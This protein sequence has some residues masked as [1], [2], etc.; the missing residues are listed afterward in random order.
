[1]VSASLTSGAPSSPSCSFPAGGK[2]VI[3]GYVR[4]RVGEGEVEAIGEK[5]A[6]LAVS[7]GGYVGEMRVEGDSAFLLL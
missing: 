6:E 7:L 4:L 2:V 3:D 5:A 1:M